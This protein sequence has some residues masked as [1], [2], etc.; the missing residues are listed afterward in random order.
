MNTKNLILIGVLII[1]SFLFGSLLT[2]R[3]VF[4][5]FLGVEEEVEG[6]SPSMQILQDQYA[7]LEF[8]V[9]E[10]QSALIRITALET[11]VAQLKE[12]MLTES[13]VV[14]L[15]EAS[16]Q[17]AKADYD[18]GWIDAPSPGEKDFVDHMLGT[19]EFTVYIWGAYW[20][21]NH[22]VYHQH[23]MSVTYAHQHDLSGDIS[24]RT[25]LVWESSEGGENMLKITR[26]PNDQHWEQIRILIYKIP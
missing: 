23:D 18:S 6:L 3:G 24:A 1:I 25:G 5:N 14:D 11:E 19:T 13:K 21:G 7:E 4:D 20:F 17:T 9:A 15:I 10:S 12:N 16:A 22:W 8:Q 2:T 26:H